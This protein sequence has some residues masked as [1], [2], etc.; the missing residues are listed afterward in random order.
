MMPLPHETNLHGLRVLVVEDILLVAELI[1]DQLQEVG[2]T[3]VGPVPRLDRGLAL[4]V[5]EPLDGAIL[6][7]NLAGEPCFPIADALVKRGIPIAFL[8]GYDEATLPA[9]YRQMP[10]LAK[11]FQLGDLVAVVKR[12]FVRDQL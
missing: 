12:H 4:A 11:P 3:V 2:C 6:D 9:A 5:G 7:I 10:R 1:V 8:T